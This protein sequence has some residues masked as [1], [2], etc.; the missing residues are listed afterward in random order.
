MILYEFQVYNIMIWYFYILWNDHYG[1][2]SYRLSTKLWH[3]L[4]HSPYCTLYLCDLF[5]VYL[6]TYKTYHTSMFSVSMSVSILCF[7]TFLF[8]DSTYKYNYAEFAFLWLIP[9]SIMPCRFTHVINPKVSFFLWLCYIAYIYHIF[10]MHS[11]ISGHLGCVYI[12][13]TLNN[14]AMNIGGTYTFSNL[15]F[16]SFGSRLSRNGNVESYGSSIFNFCWLSILTPI[17]AAPI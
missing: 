14:A 1:K 10:F 3:C 13:V 12:L 9:C 17:V 8:S 2:S 4:L 16:V 6:E 5:T 11:S 15:C 7:F